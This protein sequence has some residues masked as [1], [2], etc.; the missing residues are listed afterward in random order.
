MDIDGENVIITRGL[1]SAKPDIIIYY[2]RH[3]P[4][5]SY[6]GEEQDDRWYY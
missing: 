5:D 6:Y 3:S 4:A 1:S 2:L